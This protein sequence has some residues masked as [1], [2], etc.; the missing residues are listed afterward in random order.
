MFLAKVIGKVVATQKD[1]KLKGSR[2]LILR[3]LQ[4]DGEKSAQLVAGKNTVVAVD[5]SGAG[6]GQVV[7][8]CQGS[9]ARQAYGMKELPI[10]AAV[11]GLVDKVEAFS[12]EV[13]KSQK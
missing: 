7:L 12:E 11:I 13:Y 8:F 3:P 4:I 10:D 6:V 2:L 9:S 5:S 1:D